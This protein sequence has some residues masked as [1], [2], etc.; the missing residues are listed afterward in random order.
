MHQTSNVEG[1]SL[2]VA[3]KELN[4]TGIRYA[5]RSERGAI[6]VS[7]SVSSIMQCCVCACSVLFP[8]SAFIVLSVMSACFCKAAILPQSYALPE[9]TVNCLRYIAYHRSAMQCQFSTN[10]LQLCSL[11]PVGRVVC[12]LRV[13]CVIF[14]CFQ[15]AHCVFS[16]IIC[17]VFI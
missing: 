17:D 7:Q 16:E 14:V 15:P 8:S 3:N 12:L 5:Q 1:M 4:S 6:F 10:L 13:E 11:S 9:L 2:N